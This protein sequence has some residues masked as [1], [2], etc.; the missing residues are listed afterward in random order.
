MM[1]ASKSTASNAASN[2]WDRREKPSVRQQRKRRRAMVNLASLMDKAKINNIDPP[3]YLTDVLERVVTGRTKI[4]QLNTLLPW[5]WNAERDSKV[6][7]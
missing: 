7:A 4:N 6:A 3:H 2:L 1:D 5:N